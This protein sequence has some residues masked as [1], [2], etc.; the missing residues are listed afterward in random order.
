MLVR[1]KASSCPDYLSCPIAGFNNVLL[2]VK[3]SEKHFTFI[4]IIALVAAIVI[5]LGKD[6]RK[7]RFKKSSIGVKSLLEYKIISE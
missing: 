1:V 6:I 7:P 2:K 3:P 5:E 4:P